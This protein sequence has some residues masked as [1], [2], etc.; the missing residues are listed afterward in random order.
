M[1]GLAGAIVHLVLL[2]VFFA[3]SGHGLANAFKLPS[4]SKVLLIL[5]IVAGHH[6][7]RAG[8]PWAAGSPLAS[9]SPA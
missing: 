1:N 6:R 9:S 4:R 2:V 7:R 5:A 3:W 8:D